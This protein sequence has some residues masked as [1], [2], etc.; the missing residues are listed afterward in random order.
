MEPLVKLSIILPILA[1]LSFANLAE[2]DYLYHN[3]P[4]TTTFRNNSIYKTNLDRLLSSLSSNS[5]NSTQFYLNGFRNSSA[6]LDP[7][8]VYGLFLCRGDGS[9]EVCR[10]C[11]RQAFQDIV[12]R[13]PVE[14]VAIIWYDDCLLRYSTESLFSTMDDSPSIYMWNTGNV[15]EDPTR[16]NTLTPTTLR[17]AATE[18]AAAPAGAK[19]FAVKQENFTASQNLYSL[20]Q[21]TPDLSR[22]DCNSCLQRAIAQYPTCCNG[23]PGGRVLFPSCNFRYEIYPFYNETLLVAPSPQPVVPPPPS[24]GTGGKGGLSTAAI[25]VIVA[26]ISASVALFCCFLFRW[27]RKKYNPVPEDNVGNEITNVESLKY[28]LTAIEAATNNFSDDNKLGEGGFGL[29]YKGTLPNRHEVAVKRLSR[30]SGQ[31]IEEFKNEVVLVANLQHRNLVRLLGFC[32]D[33]EEKLLVYEYVP[34]RSLDY[35]LFDPEKQEQL[36]WSR[37]Y[38]IIGGIARGILYL[39]EDSQLRIIH[40]DLKASNI[41]LDTNMNPKI[42]DFGMARIFGVDQTQGNTKKIVG[43]YGYMA[44][45]YAMHGQFSVKSDAY[46]FGVLLLEIISGKKNSSF[47]QMQGATDLVSYVWRHW[48]DGTPLEVLDPTLADTYSRN[49]VIRSIHIALLCVQEDP[50]D[51]PTMAN[52]VL[53]LDSYSVSL[54]LPEEPA[55]FLSSTTENMQMKGLALSQSMSQS[56]PCSV[57]EESITEVYPR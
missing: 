32:L 19:K 22:I 5:T 44:P 39:H 20:V 55:F 7:D 42:S 11:V 4:N 27:A 10:N 46:S 35:L 57:D 48:R 37:R 23:R 41:L 8:V 28:D 52:I 33:G 50:A 40:R 45:E 1:L 34:N 54:Q 36:D 16:F 18:A 6:G 14:K 53:M 24:L 25:V 12:Q 26:S 29:V 51:R 3:C 56:V 38:K 9:T 49:E 47:F 30:H 43:T 15:T 21:C 13:C 17:Q 31:G 2:A